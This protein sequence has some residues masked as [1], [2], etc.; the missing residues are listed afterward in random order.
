MCS[1]ANG[2]D[3]GS[4]NQTDAHRP[5]RLGHVQDEHLQQVATKG[6]DGGE[7]TGEPAQRPR[8]AVRLQEEEERA[9]KQNNAGSLAVPPHEQDSHHEQGDGG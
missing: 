2:P 1:A 8:L 9:N 6:P 4:D 3:H 5:D 7:Q